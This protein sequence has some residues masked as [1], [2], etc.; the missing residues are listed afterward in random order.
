MVNDQ[1][2]VGLGILCAEVCNA[3]RRGAGAKRKEELS[4]PVRNAIDRL[5]RC[6]YPAMHTL[7]PSTNRGFGHRSI[8][9]IERKMKK[10]AEKNRVVKYITASN[11]KSK[12]AGWRLELNGIL[13]IFDVR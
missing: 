5:E 6:V 10:Y 11:V 13:Q 3:L 12:I 1:D 8:L 4:E 9:E 2:C 7:N